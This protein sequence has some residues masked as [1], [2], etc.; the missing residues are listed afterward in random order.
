M[1]VSR[2]LAISLIARAPLDGQVW[3]CKTSVQAMIL[4]KDGE[5]RVARKKTYGARPDDRILL[6]F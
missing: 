1:E 2:A 5:R 6:P 3:F 4:V